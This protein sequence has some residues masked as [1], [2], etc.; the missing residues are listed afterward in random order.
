MKNQVKKLLLLIGIC[1]MGILITLQSAD[2]AEK[3]VQKP[4][5][6][7]IFTDQQS[8]NMMSCAGNKWLKTPAMDYI[9]TNGIR[10]TRAYTTNPVCAPARISLMTGRFP[11]AFKDIKGNQVRENAGAVRVPEVSA[12]VLQTTLPACLKKAGYDLIYGGKEHL[13]KPLI[14]VELGF[15]DITN[16]ERDELAQKAAEYIREKHE[17]PYFMVV[18]LINPHDI[19][20][21]AIRDFASTE[22]DKRILANG[23]VEIETLDKAMAKPEGVSDEEFYANYCPTLPANLEPQQDEPKAVFSL[24][25]RRP[26]RKNARANYSGENWR[27]HR[28][29]YC[30]LTEIVDEQID[31]IL[32]ALR[33][34]GQEENTLVLFASDH[35]D[36]DGSHR[37]E[38]KTALYEEATNIPFMAMWKGM[39]PGGRIDSVHLVSSGLDLLP[40]VCDYAGVI[41]KS[42]PRGKSL[43]PLFEGKSA[44]WRKTLGVESEIGRMVV[45]ENGCKYIRY[46]AMGTEERLHDL[47]VDPGEMTHF[48]TNPAYKTK[49]THLKEAFDKQWFPGF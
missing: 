31:Q 48:E 49:L 41:G 25:D 24:I 36:M 9:A 40:T 37:M 11:G 22:Q 34:S 39:I 26:F 28:W 20:Y 21:M 45:G 16:N 47:N 46:D 27:M 14:P 38:H 15:T 18:S 30:R 13:P 44:N 35:G 2:C 32:A 43:R 33:E 42:D 1:G 12:E 29:A 8:A 7:Y 3:A 23:V 5:I 19:C 10:F 17:K 4:N 6:I